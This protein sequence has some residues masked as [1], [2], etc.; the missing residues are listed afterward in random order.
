[1]ENREIRLMARGRG[2]QM[3]R[4]A[5]AMWVSEPTLYRWMREELPEDKKVQI[6]QII[7]ELE[8]EAG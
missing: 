6:M 4:V 2:V 3:W 1:M 7:A 5:K 8:Q